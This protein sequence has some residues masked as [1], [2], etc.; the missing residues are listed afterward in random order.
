MKNIKMI[1]GLGNSTKKFE[2]TRHNA[3]HWY[4]NNLA[5]FFNISLKKKK[6]GEIGTILINNLK[7]KLF[8]PNSFMNLSGIPIFYIASFYKI[9]LNNILVVHDELDLIPGI[10]QFK[11]GYG[12][13]G[14]NGLKSIINNFNQKNT[15]QHY[16]FRIR[17]GIGR[18]ASSTTIS[19]FVLSI[20]SSQEKLLINNSI[21]N[22]IKSTY[23]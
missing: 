12:H 18:P 10:V 16:F 13:N 20:P 6:E 7:I 4:I 5:K 9:K 3:G 14:H 23:T 19:N 11:K 17:I 15:A 2:K 1:V 21:K 8:K 22:N